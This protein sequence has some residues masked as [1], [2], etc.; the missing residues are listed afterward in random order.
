MKIC[1]E[2]NPGCNNTQSFFN[3]IEFDSQISEETILQQKVLSNDEEKVKL[4]C[5]IKKNVTMS[6]G[7]SL[8]AVSGFRQAADFVKSFFYFQLCTQNG[9]SA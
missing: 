3:R 7:K 6:D 5:L 4:S 2:S 8:A 9:H 1:I